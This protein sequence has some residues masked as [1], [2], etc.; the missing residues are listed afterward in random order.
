M[1]TSALMESPTDLGIRSDSEGQGHYRA[2]RGKR[3]HAGTDYL[4]KPGQSVFSP[5]AGKIKRIAY[6]YPDKQYSGVVIEGEFF[7][8]KLFYFKPFQDLIGKEVSK[9]EHIGNA[10]DISLRYSGDMLPHVHLQVDRVD[11]N[12]FIGA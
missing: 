4:C 5:I 1:E 10:Q 11:P 6:P 7:T 9:G 3:L 2:K 8:I 12:I